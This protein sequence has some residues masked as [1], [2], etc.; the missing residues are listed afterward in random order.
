[1]CAIGDKYFGY[2]NVENIAFFW[3]SVNVLDSQDSS[4]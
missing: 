4:F 1:M 2:A 3:N